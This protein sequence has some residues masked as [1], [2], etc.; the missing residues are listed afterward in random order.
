MCCANKLTNVGL[1]N[2]K[3]FKCYYVLSSSI[4]LDFFFF[5]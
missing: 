3:G 4:N 2:K 5:S 1:I